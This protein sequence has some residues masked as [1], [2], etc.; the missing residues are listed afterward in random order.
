MFYSSSYRDVH[1]S[2]EL[3]NWAAM[4][5]NLKQEALS[6]NKAFNNDYLFGN[7]GLVSCT[8]DSTAD[9]DVENAN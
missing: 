7:S 2:N 4:Q 9:D 1:T 8:A 6:K 5:A 3:C